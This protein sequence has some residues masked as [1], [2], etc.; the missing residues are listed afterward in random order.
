MG[1]IR[2]QAEGCRDSYDGASP[3]PRSRQ[4]SDLAEIPASHPICAKEAIWICLVSDLVRMKLTSFRG[5]ALKTLP[6]TNM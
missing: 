4:A 2:R 1:G 6:T 3:P 5:L